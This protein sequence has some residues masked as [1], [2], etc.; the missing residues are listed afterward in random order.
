MNK[1]QICS[2]T[3]RLTAIGRPTTFRILEFF[4]KQEKQ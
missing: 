3:E 4:W 1:T 2:T